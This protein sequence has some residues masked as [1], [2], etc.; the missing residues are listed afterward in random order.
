MSDFY[1]EYEQWKQDN[2]VSG[3]MV[4]Y[5]E[6]LEAEI[7]RQQNLKEHW[8]DAEKGQ[9]KI[10][11]TLVQQRD[12]LED[13][14]A[15][16]NEIIDHADNRLSE[17]ETENARMRAVLENIASNTESFNT[18][19]P[20][21]ND[22]YL[23]IVYRLASA[24]LEANHASETEASE[25]E[26]NVELIRCPNCNEILGEADNGFHTCSNCGLVFV[27]PGEEA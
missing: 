14:L 18:A 22:W 23:A 17:L 9:A 26:D 12:D 10:V 8:E 1:A 6:W 13:K 24:A 11:Q 19:N 27:K 15:A 16:A 7:Q 4:N 3:T 21:G 5:T 25:T 20:P 2:S